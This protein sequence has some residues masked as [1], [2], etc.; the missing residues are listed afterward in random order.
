[1]NCNNFLLLNQN[2]NNNS[3][4]LAYNNNISHITLTFD[5]IKLKSRL[6]RS[7]GDCLHV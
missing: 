4:N 5:I 6:W 7:S 1:M 2:N 3:N